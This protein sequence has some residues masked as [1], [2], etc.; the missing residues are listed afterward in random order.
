MLHIRY[1]RYE[2]T[3]Y[4]TLS[5]ATQQDKAII[6]RPASINSTRGLRASVG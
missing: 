2:P 3:L 4:S 5:G 1:R 6:P